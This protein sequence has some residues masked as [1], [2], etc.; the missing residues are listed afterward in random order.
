MNRYEASELLDQ[1]AWRLKSGDW[2]NM[3]RKM[4]TG[5]AYWRVARVLEFLDGRIEADE[6]LPHA[7][8]IRCIHGRLVRG[9]K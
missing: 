1:A 2:T 3:R 5:G 6:G 7:R 4:I 9:A 8:F